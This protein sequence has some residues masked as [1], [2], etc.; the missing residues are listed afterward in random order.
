MKL[1]WILSAVVFLFIPHLSL[2]AS[3]T[4]LTL[5]RLN[6]KS[7]KKLHYDVVYDDA[8]CEID[9][10]SPFD[11]YYRDN[12]TGERLAEFSKDSAKYFGPKT[13]TAVWTRETVSL[14]FTAFDEIKKA[15]NSEE[16]QILVSVF[17]NAQG[18]C[19]SKAEFVSA[20]ETYVL[21]N[22]DIQATKLLGVPVGVDWVLLTGETE[23][24]PVSSC[25]VGSCN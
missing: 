10:S 14:E 16:K 13:Q 11:V 8:T 4:V 7:E 3:S 18:G 15:T 21:K 2:A 20:S 19:E 1:L 12:T 22:I 17:A 5:Q 24:G 23:I 25:V 6:Y 9:L